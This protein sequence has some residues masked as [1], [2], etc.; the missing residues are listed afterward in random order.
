MTLEKQIFY[1]Y[2]TVQVGKS[3]YAEKRKGN[4][5]KKDRKTDRKKIEMMILL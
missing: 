1:I 2:S 4:G 3:V 5:Y